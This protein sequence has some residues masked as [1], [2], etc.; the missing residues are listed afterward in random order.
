MN[1]NYRSPVDGYSAARFK[2]GKGYLGKV[3][4]DIDVHYC[5]K[6]EGC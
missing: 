2:K 5:W 3:S 4:G 1:N 6:E